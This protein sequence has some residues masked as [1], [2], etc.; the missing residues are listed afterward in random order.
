MYICFESEIMI[1]NYDN[2]WATTEAELYMH[3]LYSFIKT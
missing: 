2:K 3:A 1:L